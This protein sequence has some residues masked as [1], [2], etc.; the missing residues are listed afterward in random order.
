MSV[1]LGGVI[2]GDGVRVNVT[3]SS[4]N[5][6]VGGTTITV[7]DSAVSAV[8]TYTAIH[9]SA[10]AYVV[11]ITGLTDDYG[12]NANY[13]LP[14]EGL[15]A[16][17]TI[18]PKAVALT[19]SAADSA[20]NAAGGTTPNFVVTYNGNDWTMTAAATYTGVTAG[21]SDAGVYAGDSLEVEVNEVMTLTYT[22]TRTAKNYNANVYS[23]TA[24]TTNTDY[25]VTND[26][27]TLAINKRAISASFSGESS[28]VYNGSA[29]GVTLSISNVVA[30]DAVTV[31]TTH[32][33]LT[34]TDVALTAET[35]LGTST[36]YTATY[37]ATAV[38][39]YTVSISN[40]DGAAAANYS[41][42]TT[43]TKSYSI[44]TKGITVTAIGSKVYDGDTT[45]TGAITFSGDYED[46]NIS[47]TSKT[48]ADANVGTGMI[49]FRYYI[50]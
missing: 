24:S 50:A 5:I 34:G 20:S 2:S 7:S 12:D 49:N 6:N 21:S 15:E 33:N 44:I 43:L 23:V 32:A 35:S 19:W 8:E 26:E 13:V 29:Q 30:G 48:Y 37:A 42:D 38:G 1:E 9:A 45:V 3:K 36:T 17:F 28:L 40:L 22:G 16:S 27:A 41:I 39:S 47:V 11:T 31:I 4:A 10:E 18:N 25:T 14:G 46:G